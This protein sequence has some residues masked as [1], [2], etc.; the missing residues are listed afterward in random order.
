MILQTARE[1]ELWHRFWTLKDEED[2]NLDF[3]SVLAKTEF[4]KAIK[5][6]IMVCLALSCTTASTKRTFSTLRR[7]KTWLK[8]TMAHEGL[9]G[10]CLI[11]LHRKLVSNDQNFKERL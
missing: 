4:Y 1:L 5:K 9:S 11:S 2:T 3:V 8:S 7:V 10:L 6:A